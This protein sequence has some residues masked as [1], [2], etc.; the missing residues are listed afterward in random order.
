MKKGTIIGAYNVTENIKT[1]F[2]F[3]CHTEVKGFML[4]KLTWLEILEDVPELRDL[5]K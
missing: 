3:R 1:H 2:V 5:I 4:R